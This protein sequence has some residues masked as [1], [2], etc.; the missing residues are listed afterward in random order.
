MTE[1]ELAENYLRLREENES[2]N[3]Q[4]EAYKQVLETRRE[5][6]ARADE[7]Y[8]ELC[9]E[10]KHL[11]GALESIS[12]GMVIVPPNEQVEGVVGYFVGFAEAVLKG[13]GS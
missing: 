2:L 4:I 10:N 7:R 5:H 12:K 9:E 13:K 8:Y 6:E 11:R 3:N 1:S